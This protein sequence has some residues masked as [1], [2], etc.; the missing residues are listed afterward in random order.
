MAGPIR[1]PP[2]YLV[3]LGAGLLALVVLNVLLAPGDPGLLGVQ[4]HPA[5]LLI[6]IV[7]SRHGL[8][9]GLV[10]GLV[11]AAAIAGCIVARLDHVSWTELR[12]LHH[13]VTPLLLLATGFAL[14]ALREA[15]LRET[16]AVEARVASLEQELADQ[17]VRFMAATEAKHEL[18][19]RVADERASLSSLYTA[20]RALE[21]L[22]ADRLYPAIALTAR[23]FL[24][25]DACQC[26]ALEGDL[27]RLRAAE[28]SPP[29]RSEIRP[30]EGLVG[31]A[32]RLGR[33][34]SVRDQS[35]HASVE[36]LASASLL[37]AAPL[38]ADGGALLGCV[39]VTA[40]PFL[41]LTPVALDR[42]GL[43][44]DWGA[45]ALENARAHERARAR[46]IEDELVRAYTYA[47]YQRRIHEEEVRADRYGRPLSVL[48]FRIHRYGAVDAARRAELGRVLSMVFSRTLRDVDIV[49]R[50]ATED[51]FAII[52]PETAPARAEIVLDR[53]SREIANFHFAPYADEAQDLEFSTRVLAVRE[54]PGGVAS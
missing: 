20:A 17:A 31:L 28:G 3:E 48:I 29:D 21:T 25:A 30:D 7:A 11:T 43:V 27:L 37:M 6:A 9:A 54:R 46:T 22:E 39:T 14:G 13:Y 32:I 16:R 36:D 51:S 45:R 1:R 44:A 15:H 2:V 24:Q 42:L 8:R 26:Y 10:S 4:P 35:Q 19:R 34:V 47:Y 18:E 53:L 50:Y 5:L 49:C 12:T 33:P 23:R 38:V 52:L 41:R 40:L